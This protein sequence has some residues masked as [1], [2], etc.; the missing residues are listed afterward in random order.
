MLNWTGPR[1]LT[2]ADLQFDSRKVGANSCF[3]AVRGTRVDGHT[4]LEQTLAQGAVALVVED[5]VDAPAGVAV[6]QVEDTAL[7]LG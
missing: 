4:F 1:D 3:I 5:P 6:I 2:I 7:A